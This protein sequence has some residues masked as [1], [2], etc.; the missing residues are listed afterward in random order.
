MKFIQSSEDG[1]CVIEFSEEEKKIIQEKS[2][3]YLTAET[4]KHFGN[5]LTRIVAEWNFN[6]NDEIKIKQTNDN[7]KIEGK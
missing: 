6:F 4:L 7:T 3:L 5:V 1:S 2:G